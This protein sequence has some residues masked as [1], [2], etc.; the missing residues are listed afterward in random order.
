MESSGEK[1][2]DK[3]KNFRQ[4]ATETRRTQRREERAHESCPYI[5]GEDEILVVGKGQNS[6]LD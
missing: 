3:R 6:L 4:R 1:E 2:K 5:G